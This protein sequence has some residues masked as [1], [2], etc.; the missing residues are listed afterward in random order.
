MLNTGIFLDI[1]N[2]KA[3]E[4]AHKLCETLQRNQNNVVVFYSNICAI[5]KPFPTSMI[6]KDALWGFSGNLICLSIDLA[7]QASKIASDINVVYSPDADENFDP[8]FFLLIKNNM[9]IISNDA[10]KEKLIKRTIG[11]NREMI[12]SEDMNDLLRAAL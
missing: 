4:L 7:Q 12:Y 8:L 10:D 9:K 6:S 11:Q 2:K 1:R 3:F 5:E